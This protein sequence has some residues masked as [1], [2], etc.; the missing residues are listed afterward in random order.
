MRASA[1]QLLYEVPD[2]I[3]KDSFHASVYMSTIA[4]CEDLAQAVNGKLGSH[5]LGMS[6]HAVKK[7]ARHGRA[8][9]GAFFDAGHAFILQIVGSCLGYSAEGHMPRSERSSHTP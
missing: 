6:V 7:M 5:T 3:D 9:G 2:M 8:S 1:D 4:S